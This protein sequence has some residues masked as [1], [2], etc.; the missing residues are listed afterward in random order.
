DNKAHDTEI[1][2]GAGSNIAVYRPSQQVVAS[3]YESPS[4]NI[5]KVGTVDQPILHKGADDMRID[6]G[7]F[8]VASEKSDNPIQYITSDSKILAGIKS[9]NPKHTCVTDKSL[10][11]HT[12][13]RIRKVGNIPV[14]KFIAL[15]FDELFTIQ[16]FNTNLCPYWNRDGKK[17]T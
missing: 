15:A 6:W 5:L 4:L 14:N 12:V 7:Y 9:T 10:A 8:Y 16:Y 17:T 11:L 3:K 13:I 2:L 1:L